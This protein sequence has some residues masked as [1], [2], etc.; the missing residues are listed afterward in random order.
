VDNR[1]GLF[2]AFEGG[3]Y[4]SVEFLV[5][6]EGFSGS[7]SYVVHPEELQPFLSQLSAFPLSDPAQLIIGAEFPDGPLVDVTIVRAD[8]RGTL[9]VGVKLADRRDRSR[10][11][12]TAFTCV[13]SDAIR[14][15]EA[16]QLA[17]EHGGEVALSAAE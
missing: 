10:R 14:F 12:S 7:T 5:C 2:I 15:I 6:A 4:G 17:M 8:L 9:E 3:G 16:A 1:T 13:H 11:V